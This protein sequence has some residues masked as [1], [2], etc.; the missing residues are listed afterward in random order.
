[1]ES[2][3]A[4]SFIS[5]CMVDVLLVARSR[6][7]RCAPERAEGA[8]SVTPARPTVGNCRDQIG[9]RAPIA[10]PT[11]RFLCMIGTRKAQNE[12][13]DSYQHNLLLESFEASLNSEALFVSL[14]LGLVVPDQRL[15]IQP[16]D[17]DRN[18][19]QIRRQ[20]E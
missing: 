13:T 8:A 7:S 14:P 3:S 12:Q 5:F 9:A 16:I 15:I 11:Q 2:A 1:M 4:A 20:H 17:L 6:N 10:I 19:A 18:G